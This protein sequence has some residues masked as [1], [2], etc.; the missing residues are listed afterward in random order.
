MN[1]K[2]IAFLGLMLAF[3]LV[4]AMLENM[5]PPLFPMLPPQFSRIGLSNVVVMYVVFF[6]GKKEAI[7]MA[8]LKAVFGFLMRGPIAGLTSLAG[9]LLSVFFIISLLWIFRHKISYIA[10][11]VA[12]AIGH[13]LGQ[14]IIASAILDYWNFFVVLFPYMLISGV[15]FGTITGIFL[16]VLMTVFD[17]IQKGGG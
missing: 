5:L 2:K 10:L 12:G 3:I 9:G 7:M 4:L 8:V 17:K 11:S 16:K 1:T 15:I 13:N 14:L 6:V